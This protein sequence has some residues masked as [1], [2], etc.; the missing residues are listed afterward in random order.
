MSE[1]SRR[2]IAPAYAKPPAPSKPRG[3]DESRISHVEPTARD[4]MGHGHGNKGTNMRNFRLSSFVDRSRPVPADRKMAD[5]GRTSPEPAR[6]GTEAH[7]PYT[8]PR[9]EQAEA[10][11]GNLDEVLGSLSHARADAEALARIIAELEAEAG[12]VP[13]LIEDRRELGRK[14]DERAGE[15]AA[16]DAR[17]EELVRDLARA[18]EESAQVQRQLDSAM[19]EPADLHRANEEGKER[20]RASAETIGQLEREAERTADAREKS[21]REIATL[22]G[23]LAERDRALDEARD[24]MNELRV[25]AKRDA[26]R[27]AE[28]EES[29]SRQQARIC[30]LTARLAAANRRHDELE[31]AHDALR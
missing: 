9:A 29:H 21:E 3:N 14:L 20:L 28:I 13:G 10:L 2:R 31:E 12:R 30:D 25:A 22:R 17:A 11:R 16:L 23:A 27:I 15:I 26:Q 4:P 18:R 8:P 1:Q 5:T 7:G 24:A 6:S 19:R